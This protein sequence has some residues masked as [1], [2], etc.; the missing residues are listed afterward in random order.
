MELFILIAIGGGIGIILQKGFNE[1]IKAL[2]S[3]DEKLKSIEE[4]LGK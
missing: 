2:A 4:K 1:M 3:I